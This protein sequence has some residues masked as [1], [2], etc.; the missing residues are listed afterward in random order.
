MSSL[1]KVLVVLNLVLTLFFLGV[2]ATVFTTSQKWVEVSDKAATESKQRI[3]GLS[4]R[5][6]DQK[7]KNSILSSD[8]MARGKDIEKLES[9]KTTLTN[10]RGELMKTEA[11]LQGQIEGLNDQLAQKDRMLEQRDSEISRLQQSKDKA[12]TDASAAEEAKKDAEMR[13]ARALLDQQNLAGDNENLTKQLTSVTAELDEKQNMITGAQR[14]G[15]DWNRVFVNPPP[16]PI[17]GLVAAVREDVGLVVFTVGADDKVQEGQEFVIYREGGEFIGKARVNRVTSD[18][19]GARLLWTENGK[20]VRV[21]DKVHTDT[22][23]TA[24]P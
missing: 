21:G 10:D 17:S 24:T 4:S 6:D 14:A 15:F 19:S 5:L 9:E 13:L 22:S 8:L 23:T 7:N 12:L 11:R 18:M 2:S 3:E 20:Q 1:A 16:P